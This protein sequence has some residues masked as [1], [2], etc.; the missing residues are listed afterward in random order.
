MV[1]YPKPEQ[2]K[3]EGSERLS[4]ERDMIKL[5]DLRFEDGKL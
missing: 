2:R 3:K 5:I 4:G 1:A